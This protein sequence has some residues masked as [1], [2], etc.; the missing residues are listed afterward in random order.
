MVSF[1]YSPPFLPEPPSIPTPENKDKDK[2]NWTEEQDTLLLSLAKK[3]DRKWKK[4]SEEIKTKNAGQCSYRYNKLNGKYERKYFSERDKSLFL[5]AIRTYGQDWDQ[6]V[7]VMKK[8]SKK[9]LIKKYEKMKT[10]GSLT[11]M[12]NTSYAGTVIGESTRNESNQSVL[13]DKDEIIKDTLLIKFNKRKIVNLFFYLTSIFKVVKNILN[14]HP[15]TSNNK[16]IK[17]QIHL[18]MEFIHQFQI[19]SKQYK[20]SFHYVLE[21]LLEKLIQC[22]NQMAKLIKLSKLYCIG[23]KFN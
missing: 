23:V 18:L 21:E 17:Q 4:V 19:I 9:I 22:Y 3:F 10:E 12:I 16:F 15:N 11:E 2:S 1:F 8:F 7:L 20:F 14:K 6:I 5:N 13:S